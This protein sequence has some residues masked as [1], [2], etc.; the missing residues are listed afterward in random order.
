M[1]TINAAVLRAIE[2]LRSLGEEH[3]YKA[4]MVLGNTDLLGHSMDTLHALGQVNWKLHKETNEEERRRFIV[5]PHVDN[6]DAIKEVSD[7]TLLQVLRRVVMVMTG[8]T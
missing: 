1:T 2:E 7:E 3:D 4:T 8:F 6:D 5:D